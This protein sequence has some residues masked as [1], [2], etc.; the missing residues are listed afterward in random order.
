MNIVR[1]VGIDLP[2]QKNPQLLA[3]RAFYDEPIVLHVN[4][5]SLSP[6]LPLPHSS[7]LQKV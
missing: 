6:T 5:E 1:F 2:L 7:T 4:E 3:R